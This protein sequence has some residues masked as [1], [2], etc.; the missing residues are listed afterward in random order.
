MEN[1]ASLPFNP[2]PHHK[3]KI[4]PQFHSVKLAGD[5][6]AV[7]DLHYQHCHNHHRRAYLDHISKIA[8]KVQTCIPN[9]K[10]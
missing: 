8:Q 5:G 6:V 4:P 10:F 9:N 7:L 2:L 3:L 1:Q